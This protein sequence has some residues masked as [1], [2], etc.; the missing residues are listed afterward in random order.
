MKLHPFEGYKERSIAG[1]K[2]AFTA[3]M[4]TSRRFAALAS[5]TPYGYDRKPEFNTETQNIHTLFRKRFSVSGKV[6]C[7]RLFITGDDLYK[8]YL[9]GRYIG[10]GPAQSFPYAYNYNCYDVT[11]LLL[12]GENLL[13]VHLY[14]QGL[15]NIYMMSA[16]HR[17]ALLCELLIEYENGRVERIASDEG[18]KYAEC[19]AFATRYLYGYQTQFSED[20]DLRKMPVGWREAGFDDGGWENA[21]CLDAEAEGYVFQPQIT[22]SVSYRRIFPKTV[23]V[24]PNG[25]LLDF[26]AET[27]GTLCFPIAGAPGEVIELRYAEELTEEGRARYEIRAN[28]TYSDRITL[29]GE[30]TLLEYFDYKGFRYAEILHPPKD[31]D[32]S[33]VSALERH[34]PFPEE[35]ADFRC[36]DET[37]NRIFEICKRGV[38]IGT[39]DTYY[40]CPTREKGGFVGDAL[41]TGLAHL[42]LTGDLS[43]YKKFILD[44]KETG[45][46]CPVI[47]AHLPTYNINFC[48]DYSLLIP[49]FVKEYY[50][51]TGDTALVSEML[52]TLEGIL[53][54]FEKFRNADGLLEKI[55]HFD[56]VPDY[57]NPILIDWPQNLRD[58]YDMENATR[59]V[60]T[61]VNVFYYGFQKTAAALYR[62]AKNE[63]R[64]EALSNAAAQTEQGLNAK[65]YDEE[66]GLY[67]DATNSRHSAIHANALQLFFGMKP[68][69]GYAPIRD[70]LLKRRLNCGVYFSYFV[71]EGLFRIGEAEAALNLLRGEDEHSW[72]NMLRDGATTC[73]EAWGAEQK[74]NTSWCHPWSSSPIYFYFCR[75]LGIDLNARGEKRIRIAPHLP[76]D[77][78]FAALEMPSPHGRIKAEIRRDGERLLCAVDAPKDVEIL[79]EGEGIEYLRK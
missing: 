3:P 43:I 67:F 73:M 15:F 7:A 62:I 21:V 54:Y 65:L 35:S 57:L 18:W 14:Y 8:V 28:C 48:A 33:S 69:K 20:I 9:G 34:Y 26:G 40:D 44:C 60:C 77:M 24:I 61:T 31:F 68:P 11:D 63:A 42:L 1:E 46:H 78:D 16:D 56:G 59:G 32:P 27:V 76:K 72:A 79:F 25:Y 52:P 17:C 19:E 45:K 41:I 47:P 5:F 12:E 13:A 38:R 37:M 64:A 23:T 50:E 29:S 70:L 10:E 66:S 30:E 22:P 53:G 49:L 71:I 75:I 55:A 39:Q 6:K 2:N 4:I 51:R 36:S 74:W 58:G